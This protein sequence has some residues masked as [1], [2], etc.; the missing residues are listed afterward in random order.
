[1]SVCP[2]GFSVKS[3]QQ[4]DAGKYWCEVEFRGSTISSEPAWI[5]VE[6]KS[7]NTLKSINVV[8]SLS[9]NTTAFFFFSNNMIKCIILISW[10]YFLVLSQGVPHFTLEPQDVA[11]IPGVPFNLTCTA[12]GPPGPVEVLW[13]L[14]GVQEGDVTS[15]PSVLHVNGKSLPGCFS[16]VFTQSL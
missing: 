4:Q 1:M 7:I 10:S 12:V 11:T 13:W 8:L 2:G 6:G 16:L 3:V 9:F 5:T 14:G 15:S